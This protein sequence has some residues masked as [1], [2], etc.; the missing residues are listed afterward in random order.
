MYVYAFLYGY[1]VVY[2]NNIKGKVCVPDVGE[3]LLK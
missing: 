1:L 3:E 2:Q